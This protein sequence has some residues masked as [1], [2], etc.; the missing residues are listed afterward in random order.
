MA[1]PGVVGT[2]VGLSS[3]GRVVIKVYVEKDTPRVR[4][5]VPSSL[6]AIPVEIE[7]TGPIVAY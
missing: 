6:E 2:G 7:E 1:I 5:S 4:A 3:H